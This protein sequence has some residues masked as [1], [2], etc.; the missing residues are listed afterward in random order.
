MSPNVLEEGFE[1]VLKIIQQFGWY[2]VFGIIL[3]YF[4][5]PKIEEFRRQRSLAEANDPRRK[6]IL[7]AERIRIRQRQQTKLAVD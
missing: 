7:D 2:V 1:F 3:L 6:A 5:W 4:S